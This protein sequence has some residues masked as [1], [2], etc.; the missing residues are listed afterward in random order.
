LTSGLRRLVV[1]TNAYPYPDLPY[2]GTFVDTHVRHWR[3]SGVEVDVFFINGRR[4]KWNYLGGVLAW[5]L[6]MAR[7]GRQYDAIVVHHSYCCLIAACLRWP[8]IPIVYQV[9]EGTIHFS[10]V[11]RWMVRLAIRAADRVVYVSSNLPRTLGLDPGKETILPSGIDL[12]RFQPMPRDE[13]RRVLGWALDEEVVLYAAK[14]R[15]AYERFDLVLE[16]VRRL[17]D[18]G[19]HPRLLRLE[20]VE[21]ER[22]PLYLNAADV[23]VLASRG[24]GSPK[25]VMEA[26]ACERPVVSLRVGSVPER[27]EGVKSGFLAEETPEDLTRQLLRA[28]ALKGRGAGRERVL[29]LGVERTSSAFLEICSDVIRRKRSLRIVEAHK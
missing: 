17:A 8:G 5:A 13:A 22:V 15:P 3:G 28:L 2:Y 26:L 6:A 21:R 25:I 27:L 4:S 16:A 23:L 9:H 12:E 20:G 10:R 24:E 11:N 18:I 29:D 1:F 14:E 19:R 7:R